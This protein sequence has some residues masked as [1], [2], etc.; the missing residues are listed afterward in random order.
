MAKSKLIPW[1]LIVAAVVVA[2]LAVEATI[3]SRAERKRQALYQSIFRQYL[4]AL[5]PGTQRSE[6]EAILVSQGRAFQQSC[7]LLGENQNALEDVVKI[8][9]EPKLWYCSDLDMYLVFEFESPPGPVVRETDASDRLRRIALV[10]WLG[11]CL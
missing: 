8:G 5:K 3:R 1:L 6:V 7:C 11:F 9:S 10:P 4:T 2:V